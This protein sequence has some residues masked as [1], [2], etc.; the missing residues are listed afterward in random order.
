MYNSR[1]RYTRYGNYPS[2]LN[3]PEN[4]SGNAFRE[5][6]LNGSSDDSEERIFSDTGKTD[7]LDGGVHDIGHS[8]SDESMVSDDKGREE[9]NFIEKAD[10]PE[11]ADVREEKESAE[12][13]AKVQ[14]KGL[15][16]KANFGFNIG[17]LF[18]GGFGFEELLLIG[19]ILLVAQNDSNDDIIILLAL[20]LFI[21]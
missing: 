20:L 5:S 13:S 14:K 10:T 4:Y 16:P 17:K 2:E 19:L 6:I 7:I 9:R 12:C 8:Q 11:K 21:S 18:S 3:V 1:P 15:F